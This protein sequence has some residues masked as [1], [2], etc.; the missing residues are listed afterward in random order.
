MYVPF[1]AS[2]KDKWVFMTRKKIMYSPFNMESCGRYTQFIQ[3][4]LIHTL[5][6]WFKSHCL[7]SRPPLCITDSLLTFL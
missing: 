4:T 7:P 1:L 5:N 2:E 3:R 6:L